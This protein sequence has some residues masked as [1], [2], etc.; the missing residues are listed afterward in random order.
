MLMFFDDFV[1]LLF[2]DYLFVVYNMF[3]IVVCVCFVVCIM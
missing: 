2:F 1:L 3:G